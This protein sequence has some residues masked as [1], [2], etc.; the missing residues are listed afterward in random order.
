MKFRTEIFP[1]KI[2]KPIAY[3][4]KILAIGSCFA[5]NIGSRLTALKYDV[6]INPFG[7]QYNPA[8]IADGLNRIIS[9]KGFE[10]KELFEYNEAWHSF[11]HHSD[12]SDESPNIALA[13]MNN[14]L[15]KAA[16]NIGKTNFLM[17]TLGTAWVFILKENSAIVSNCHKLPAHTFLRKKL[18]V[19]E[20]FTLLKKPLEILCASN[21]D[22]Q[23]ILSIS[24]IRHLKD[25][26]HENQISKAT[27]FLA[28]EK[29]SLEF[30]NIH[31]FPAYEMMMD[32]LRDYR[33]YA[34]DMTHPSSQAIDYIWE[35]FEESCLLT[36]EGQLR[37]EISRLIMAVNHRLF[38]PDS[39]K[40]R[41]FARTQLGII[42]A[43]KQEAS[44][45]SFEPEFEYFNSILYSRS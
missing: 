8:S 13:K 11:S 17:L 20:A 24:P 40:S 45:I 25:G 2:S 41:K 37:K 6:D 16:N 10:M 33:F 4:N 30:E 36:N 18:S 42:E 21:P 34:S 31:Y 39:E 5:E 35:K 28:A 44:T 15:E 12:F 32:D 1:E 9:G 27:L 22:L 14:R 23:I 3:G 26:M 38:N 43:L 19:E 7:I 29:L